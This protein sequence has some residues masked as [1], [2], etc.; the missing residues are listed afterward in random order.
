MK[1]QDLNQKELQTV[2]NWAE[3]RDNANWPVEVPKAEGTIQALLLYVDLKGETVTEAALDRALGDVKNMPK[4]FAEFERQAYPSL[5]RNGKIATDNATRL[6]SCAFHEFG[7]KS[8]SVDTLNMATKLLASRGELR[9][10]TP[11]PTEAAI[12]QKNQQRDGLRRVEEKSTNQQAA[13]QAVHLDDANQKAFERLEKAYQQ[14]DAKTKKVLGE[15]TARHRKQGV[16]WV[17]T[18]A[19]SASYTFIQHLLAFPP[20]KT[21]LDFQNF[22]DDVGSV[23]LAEKGV[24]AND[25]SD[26]AV[27]SRI[28]A[29]L[30]QP[31]GVL[32][33]FDRSIK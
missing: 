22:R 14:S 24:E 12:T 30:E 6:F 3:T 23:I 4:V 9:W 31:G 7:K 18:L 8:P 13:N 21:H 33:R 11:L 16:D 32:S 20:G 25:P 26:S 10:E 28:R 29:T 17:G 2:A 5:L 1:Y 27:W 15:I 19:E